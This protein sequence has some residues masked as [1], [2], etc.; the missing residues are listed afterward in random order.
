MPPRRQ[1][2]EWDFQRVAYVFL[3]RALPEGAYV[4]SID[5]ARTGSQIQRIKDA[6]RGILAGEL[7]MEVKLP[8]FEA[9]KIELKMPG[10]TLS[11]AQIVTMDQWRRNGGLAFAAWSLDEIEAGLRGFGVPLRASAGGRWEEHLARMQ[12]RAAKP[13]KARGPMQA[14]TPAT[15]I[16]RAE[17]MRD[18]RRGGVLF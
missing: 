9:I 5:S 11:E 16:R 4:R 15:K 7:D 2:P 3:R 18:P 14:R 6:E 8:G 13:K 12:K 1:H 10:N 17:A